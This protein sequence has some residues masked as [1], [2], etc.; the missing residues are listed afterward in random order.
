MKE[1]YNG[2]AAI[3]FDGTLYSSAKGLP[4][5]EQGNP[6]GPGRAKDLPCNYNREEFSLLHESLRTAG[7]PG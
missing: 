2:L 4:E 5:T 3:D 1:V 6:G 7:S